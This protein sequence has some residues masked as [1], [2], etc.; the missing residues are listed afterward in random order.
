M[1]ITDQ[2][3]ELLKLQA[4]KRCGTQIPLDMT[5]RMTSQVTGHWGYG[6]QIFREDVKLIIGNSLQNL[7]AL[8][9]AVFELSRKSRGGGVVLAPA[10]WRGLKLPCPGRGG[11]NLPTPPVFLKYLA[12]LLLYHHYFFSTF[13]KLNWETFDAKKSKIGPEIFEI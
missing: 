9:A 13:L 8:R 10:N 12:C 1:H 2:N 3:T 4:S 6:H 7:A 11:Q 5:L